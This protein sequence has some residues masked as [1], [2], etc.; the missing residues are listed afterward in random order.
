MKE[1]F[2]RDS[3]RRSHETAEF[4][5][6][7]EAAI[8]RAFRDRLFSREQ[9]IPVTDLVE[10]MTNRLPIRRDDLTAAVR[11][12]TASEALR[13]D[14]AS[15]VESVSITARGLDRLGTLG[16]GVRP[17]NNDWQSLTQCMR[18]VESRLQGSA[19]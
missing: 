1:S 4:V 2:G 17:S 13:L 18:R 3:D 7:A 8:L 9:A 15:A 12:L 16:F 14:S 5:L 11:R 10:R 6:V 19:A